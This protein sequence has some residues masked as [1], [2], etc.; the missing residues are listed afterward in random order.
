MLIAVVAL[1]TAAFAMNGDKVA[2]DAIGVSSVLVAGVG[3]MASVGSIDDPAGKDKAGNQVKAK[4]WI[5]SSDQYDDSSGFPARNGVSRGTIPL[6]SGEY[7]EYIE[8]VED[9]PQPGGSGESGDMGPTIKNTLTF[10]IGGMGDQVLKM[11]ENGI[12]NNFYIVWEICATGNKYLGGNGCKA[13]KLLSFEGG[14]KKDGTGWTLT[15][16]NQC[17]ELWSRYTGTISTQAAQTVAADAT[18][19]PL[20][21]NNTYQ[22]T[23]G[24]EAAVTLT[25]MSGVG[26]SDVGRVITIKG[27]GGTYPSVI[28][29]GEDFL[30]ANG[31]SWTANL[32][33]QID[34]LI[35]NDAEG[36]YKFIEQSRI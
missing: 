33:S 13:M 25:T 36:T 1:P 4:M 18:A 6:K 14:A 34:F 3:M 28:A 10:I 30:V 27:S 8:S 21:A 7:W 15:F 22:L 2:K 19:I 16:E 29:S 26:A 11:L 32:G 31:E 17:G 23:D 5:I 20:V 24:T 35:F 12:G 9:S